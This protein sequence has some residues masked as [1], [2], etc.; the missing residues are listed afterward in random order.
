MRAD[1]D[2]LRLA[3]DEATTHLIVAECDLDAAR[4]VEREASVARVSTEAVRN[5]AVTRLSEARSA[6]DRRLGI[7]GPATVAAAA[8]MGP[9]APAPALPTG[10]EDDDEPV[11]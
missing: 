6:L 3:V 8:P 1:L 2:R 10:W 7:Q 4:N 5:A 11:T 9:A